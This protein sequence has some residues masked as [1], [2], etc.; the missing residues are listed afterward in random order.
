MQWQDDSLEQIFPILLLL[1]VHGLI[2][3][4]VPA[5]MRLVTDFMVSHHEVGWCRKITR[6]HQVLEK[7]IYADAKRMA[8]KI[9]SGSLGLM[10]MN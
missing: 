10:S 4:D 2:I 5:A 3:D 7:S 9:P 6:A 1:N 8:A